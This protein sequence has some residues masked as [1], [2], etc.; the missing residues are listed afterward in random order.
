MHTPDTEAP[1]I[2]MSKDRELMLSVRIP[3]RG[4]RCEGGRKDHG[5]GN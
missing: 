4:E 5:Q 1:I 3:E 2:D